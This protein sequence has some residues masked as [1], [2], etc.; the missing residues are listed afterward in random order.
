MLKVHVMCFT[1]QDS[2]EHLF[3]QEQTEERCMG[4]DLVGCLGWTVVKV[5]DVVHAAKPL[6]GLLRVQE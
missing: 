1:Y 4:D 2:H 5:V 3:R 6:G